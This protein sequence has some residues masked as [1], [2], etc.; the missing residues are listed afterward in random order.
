M[1]GW[2]ILPIGLGATAS[3]V[4]AV[5]LASALFSPLPNMKR[6]DR[7]TMGILMALLVGGGAV[8]STMGAQAASRRERA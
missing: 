4:G 6:A 1:N 2:A 3:S 7:I 5:G 8:L